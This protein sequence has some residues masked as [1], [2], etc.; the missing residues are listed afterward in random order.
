FSSRAIRNRATLGGNLATAS[1]IGDSAPVL[2]A[3]GAELVLRKRGS[4]RRLPLSEFFTGYRR[5]S[6]EHG[7]L[8]VAV[9]IPAPFPERQR[10][11]KVSKRVCDD[12]STVSAAFGLSLDSSGRVRSLTAAFGGVAAT[13]LLAMSL[14]G[15]AV[16]RP[17]DAATLALL[18]GEVGSLG[19][20]QSDVRGSAEYRRHMMGQLLRQFFYETEGPATLTRVAANDTQGAQ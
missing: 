15:A 1:P 8:I 20:P 11:Y 9:R 18:L 19:T 6:L 4:E 2:L 13:P 14:T 17:W 3:L 7:E 16:G 12:I 5:T 10:F